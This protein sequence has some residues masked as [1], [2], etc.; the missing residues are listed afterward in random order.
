M[1][2]CTGIPAALFGMLYLVY[3]D[4]AV[5]G[6]CGSRYSGVACSM[7]QA[8]QVVLVLVAMPAA[9]LC[10]LF[11]EGV[12]FR[13]Y[14]RGHEA[15]RLISPFLLAWGG[16]ELFRASIPLG[17]LALM[18]AAVGLLFA[19]SR[20]VGVRGMVW[21]MSEARF[22]RLTQEAEGERLTWAQNAGLLF[23]NTVGAVLGVTAAWKIV[24]ALA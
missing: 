19:S 20:P 8:G 4:M 6:G 1:A 12:V 24:S 23:A 14:R 10:V 5:T 18:F 21:E 16:V 7:G 2:L 15:Y 13:P 9:V 11:L 3:R 22:A 17:G